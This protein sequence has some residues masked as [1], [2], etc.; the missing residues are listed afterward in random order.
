M[1]NQELQN[2]RHSCAHLLAA[3]I[4]ELYPGSHN[5]IGPA[6]ENGFY[7]DFDMGDH[8]ISEEDFPKIETKMRELLQKWQP[9]DHKEVSVEE[10][11]K[12]FK[13]NPYKLELIEEL[14]KNNKQITINNP[15]DFLDLCKGGHAENPQKDMQD[16][17]LLS[18]AGAYL[19]KQKNAITKKS[20][21][22]L[23]CLFF[24]RRSEKVCLCGL[25]KD[26]L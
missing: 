20:D 15:G 14:A 24:Q 10:A 13:H 6:I 7:Q 25:R 18:I 2:I 4:L 3:T 16:F 5:A 11:Q 19:K 9:F 21:E 12:I 17:K 8:K 1:N 22:N 26:Q 23:I